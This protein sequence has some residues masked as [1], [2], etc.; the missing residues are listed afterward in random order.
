MQGSTAPG[1][2]KPDCWRWPLLL[3]HQPKMKHS[4]ICCKTA[5]PQAH[6]AGTVQTGRKAEVGSSPEGSCARFPFQTDFWGSFFLQCSLSKAHK[7]RKWDISEQRQDLGN[8]ISLP[9]G[10]RAIT[11]A[12]LPLPAAPQQSPC[13]GWGLAGVQPSRIPRREPAAAGMSGT[14]RMQLFLIARFCFHRLSLSWLGIFG[15]WFLFL[16]LF[17]FFLLSCILLLSGQGRGGARG[18]I[19]RQA[20]A[21][22]CSLPILWLRRDTLQAGWPQSYL[23]LIFV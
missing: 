16:S 18:A 5:P 3:P 10:E 20:I 6:R 1:S 15:G 23:T 21:M 14:G 12:S 9:C 19:T 11:P 7:Q 4:D 17:F 8:P 13:P 2:Q 22:A